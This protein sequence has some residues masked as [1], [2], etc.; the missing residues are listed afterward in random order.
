[1]FVVLQVRAY[2]RIVGFPGVDG[3]AEVEADS[4]LAVDVADR[5]TQDRAQG[6]TEQ[7]G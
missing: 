1:M 5:G 6:V 2:A 7:G 3:C 4:G